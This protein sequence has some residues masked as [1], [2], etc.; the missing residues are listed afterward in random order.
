LDATL[1]TAYHKP[2]PRFASAS[3]TPI[4]VG[5]AIAAAPLPDMIGDDTGDALSERNPAYCELTALYW[6]W[7]NAAPEKTH[8]G[9]MHY[10]RLLDLTGRAA[11]GPVE[12]RP[13]RLDI[14]PWLAEVETWLAQGEV[15]LVLP[16]LHVMGR[17]VADNYARAH[18]SQDFDAARAV[19]AADHPAYLAAFDAVAGQNG[20]RLGN[21]FLMR[22]DLFERYCAW[23]FDILFK[24]EAQALDRALYAPQQRRYLGFLGE[25]L[26]TVWAAHL[27]RTEPGLRRRE[28]SIL[29]LGETLVVPHADDDRFAAPEQINVALAA[30]D[31][32]LPHAAAML[33]SLVDHVDRSRPLNVF[34]LHDAIAPERRAALAG[35]LAGHPHAALH[36]LNT[37]GATLLHKSCEG[38]PV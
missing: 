36:P 29:N 16:R 15:D 35:V 5:R 32:Y 3:V 37:A 12:A 20:V 24:V 6:A 26:F 18:Q 34:V 22:R 33:R 38:F 23:L 19:I 9:L 14:A 1:F 31:A 10:R 21:M 28:V 4:H 11:T 8:I 17:S 30:D 27:A 25:R 13:A 2:A 7:K